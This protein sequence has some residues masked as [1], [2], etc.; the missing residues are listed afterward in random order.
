MSL[1]VHLAYGSLIRA[2]ACRLNIPEFLSLKEDTGSSESTFVKMPHCGKSH[3]MAHF[4]HD[5][6]DCLYLLKL[7][8]S[9]LCK[10]CMDKVL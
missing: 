5:K 9:C 8:F 4:V 1:H 7:H 3:V 2:I 10:L 6:L